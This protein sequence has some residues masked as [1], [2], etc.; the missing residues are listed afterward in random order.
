MLPIKNNFH[1]LSDFGHESESKIIGAIIK[2]EKS[3]DAQ[4]GLKFN[5]QVIKSLKVD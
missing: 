1:F 4:E 5:C 2:E 3:E